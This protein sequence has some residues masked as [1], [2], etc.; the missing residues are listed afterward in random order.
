MP[1]RLLK[2]QDTKWVQRVTVWRQVKD[3]IF[4]GIGVVMAAIGLKGFLLPNGF[5]DGGAMGVAL[6]LQILTPLNLSI[7]ILLVNLPFIYLGYRQVSLR[8]ALKSTLAIF[9]LALLVHYIELPTITADKLLIAVFGG[10]FLGSGIGF[11]IRGG[12]VIDGTEVLAIQVSRK[13]S[14]TVGD[15]ITVFNVC[16]FLVAAL[17]VD[18]ET[19]MYSMLT[20]FSASRTVDFLINGVEEYLGVMII[21]EYNEE[22]KSKITYDLGRGVTA[23]KADG[24]FGEKAKNPDRNVLF[25]VVTRLEVTRVLTE[26]EKIDPKAFV[27]QYPIKDT[28]GG[29]IK[30]RPLH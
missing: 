2:I 13:S 25:C 30:K 12:A 26:I 3:V 21:S 1:K 5:F 15:F 9:A 11:A 27:I 22:I 28:K 20:Y 24:G 14:L 16:L 8:F 19:A 7:L 17:M 29:M 4:I 23:F 10:F 18:L 6:L